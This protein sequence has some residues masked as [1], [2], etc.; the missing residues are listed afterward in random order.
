MS[1]L[2][3]RLRAV[4]T[5]PG[6]HTQQNEPSVPQ[7]QGKFN[8]SKENRPAL[9]GPVIL[10]SPVPSPRVPQHGP[11]NVV[12]TT[13]AAMPS[14]KGCLLHKGTEVTPHCAPSP[15]PWCGTVC[16]HREGWRYQTELGVLGIL[17]NGC[18]AVATLSY[19]C[20]NGGCS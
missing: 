8:V 10:Q 3:T 9:P 4:P 20:I 11:G 18:L 7:V 17:G 2:T 16:G 12:D 19:V 13:R 14:G 15:A 5:W 1:L 6:W